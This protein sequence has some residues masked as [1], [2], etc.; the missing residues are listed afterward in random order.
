MNSVPQIFK[1]RFLKNYLSKF[2]KDNIPN[3][4]EKWEKIQRWNNYNERLYNN[5]I[6]TIGLHMKKS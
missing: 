3:F 2:T 6:C 5:F 1:E 4:K